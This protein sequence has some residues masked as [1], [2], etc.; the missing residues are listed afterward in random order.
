MDFNLK[1]RYKPSLPYFK[2]IYEF[3]D[4]ISVLET[5]LETEAD[6]IQCVV[7]NKLKTVSISGRR[8][9]LNYGIMQITSILFRFVNNIVEIS[10]IIEIITLLKSIPKFAF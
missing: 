1:R 6:Q 8:N 4:D 9:I 2:R 10:L 3:Y 7:S 5:R